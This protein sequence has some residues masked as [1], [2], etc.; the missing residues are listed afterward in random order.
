MR[1]TILLVLLFVCPSAVAAERQCI[2]FVVGIE[3]YQKQPELNIP[4]YV[5]EDAYAVWERIKAMTKFDA[6]R[7][8]LLLAD[9]EPHGLL[10]DKTQLREIITR[11][12]LRSEFEAFLAGARK[13]DLVIIYLGG[14][15]EKKKDT[16]SAGVFFLPS[17]FRR[18]GISLL[19]AVSVNELLLE[20]RTEFAG[21]KQEAEVIVFANM[22]YAGVANALSGGDNLQTEMSNVPKAEIR[23]IRLAYIPACGDEKTFEE[24]EWGKSIFARHLLQALSGRGAPDGKITARSV[25]EYLKSNRSRA[26]GDK[27][28]ERNRAR[29]NRRGLDFPR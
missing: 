20:L 15:G 6:K 19:N 18:E 22:C 5:A 24:E 25:F 21:E 14:H 13:D 4:Q 26:E 2:A 11:D 28:T 16:P 23:Q 3:K 12:T 9:R 1:P 10:P 8:K 7:S 29:S 17:D 27:R